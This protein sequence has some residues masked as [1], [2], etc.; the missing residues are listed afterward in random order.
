MA[1]NNLANLHS[2]KNEF[3][4]ALEKYEEALKIYKALAKENP[5]AYQ[6]NYART[7]IIGFLLKHEKHLLNTAKEL[8]LKYPDVYEAQK[9]L[10]FIN[11]Q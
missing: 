4:Q 8:L 11:N 5:K 10:E 6:I 2:D 9:L 1:L 3:P 7:L